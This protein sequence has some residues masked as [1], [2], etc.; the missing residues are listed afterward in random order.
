MRLLS[1]EDSDR[2]AALIR[3]GLRSRGF[4]VDRRDT[5]ETVEPLQRLVRY[6][7][8]LLDPG[9]PDGG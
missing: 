7:L 9:L 8:V 6:D 5:P 4:A 1:I 2:F 3:D